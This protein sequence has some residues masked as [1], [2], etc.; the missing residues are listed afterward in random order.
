MSFAQ[1]PNKFKDV[2]PKYIIPYKPHPK[3]GNP[4][5]CLE[6][7][8]K[9]RFCALYPKS[10]NVE[11]MK[12]FGVS[13]ATVHRLARKLGLTKDMKVIRRKWAKAV[14]KTCEANGYYASL[15]G[16]KPS[17]AAIDATRRLRAEGFHPFA[18]LK[19]NNPRR[20]KK[21]CEQRSLKRKKLVHRERLRMAYGL[22]KLT[23]MC[24]S[25]ESLSHAAY[26]QK[27]WMIKK[28]NYFADPDHPEYVCYDSLTN[29]SL[30]MEAT[31]IRH[32]L[33]V[34][35][36]EEDDNEPNISNNGKEE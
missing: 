34:V 14:K 33:G 1:M 24:L 23:N 31:A 8:V 19:K 7:E 20:Y 28:R 29:R 13:G 30:R 2:K 22:P 12:W 15:R 21:L 3:T 36:A 25:E 9:E 27:Y 17:Q 26:S 4:M 18:S 11:M 16:R 10:T 5:L 6:G 32:G 35:E